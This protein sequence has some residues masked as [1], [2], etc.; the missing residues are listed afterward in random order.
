M[1]SAI[2]TPRPEWPGEVQ[3]LRIGQPAGKHID[4]AVIEQLVG[5]LDEELL[6]GP[7]PF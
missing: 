2:Y 4:R 3:R 7:S 6:P 1:E 5:S